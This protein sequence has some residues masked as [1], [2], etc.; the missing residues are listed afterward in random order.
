M[1]DKSELREV[2]DLLLDVAAALMGAGSHTSR[3]V[4]NVSRMAQSFGYEM[5][6][7]IFQKNITMMVRKEGQVESITL[8]RSTKHMALNFN[9]VSELSSLSWHIHDEEI[10]IPQAREKFEAIM[11]TPRLSQWIVIPL[12]ASANASFCRLFQGDWV[13]CCMVFVS[14][15][16]AFSIRQQLMKRHLNH[17]VIFA[18]VAMVA[19]F[20][21]GQALVF[22]WG[23]TP[24][25]AVATS[26][27][28][29]IP[30]VPLINSLMDLLEGH[31]LTGISRFV[32]ATMLIIGIA[33][34]FLA[35]MLI[36]GVE[37]F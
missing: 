13:S 15:F 33:I 21:A 37:K 7:T 17:A 1:Y 34:G 22:G 29:L 35:T 6:I 9:V 24:N 36:L 14:T 32:N 18:I 26:V 12:V 10:T 23:E 16:I 5:F 27:L 3:V 19:S 31:V 11:N 25:I 20:I 8:V 30:G 4:R 2:A 28:F